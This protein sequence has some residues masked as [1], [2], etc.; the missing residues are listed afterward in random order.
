MRSEKVL[1]SDDC[2]LVWDNWPNTKWRNWIPVGGKISSLS[3]IRHIITA[4]RHPTVITN[5]IE[6]M[7]EDSEWNMAME[8]D[9][10]CWLK[11]NLLY[12]PAQNMTAAEFHNMDVCVFSC[13]WKNISLWNLTRSW[14]KVSAGAGQWSV[15]SVGGARN[16][17]GHLMH[18]MQSKNCVYS[19]PQSQCISSHFFHHSL[20]CGS[21]THSAVKYHGQAGLCSLPDWLF[22][23]HDLPKRGQN[24]TQSHN[25]PLVL[26]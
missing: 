9:S 5:I 18:S 17:R 7:N 25:D 2:A 22:V 23:S 1:W 4:W 15:A 26:Q 16:R 3:Q 14:E 21:V 19:L 24:R 6:T 13:D 8:I 20:R 11:F 10:F 12:L